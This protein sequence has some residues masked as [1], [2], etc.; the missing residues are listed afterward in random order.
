MLASLMNE[1]RISIEYEAADYA[2]AIREA[3][4]LLEEDGCI[5]PDYTRAC[6]EIVQKMGAYMVLAKGLA[7]PHARPEQGALKTSVSLVILKQPVCFGHAAND[8]VK[9]VFCLAATD[10]SGHLSA[11]QDIAMFALNR[12]RFDRLATMRDPAEAFAYIRELA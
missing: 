1:R 12:P 9:I 10:N 11:L 8:P 5:T 6:I 2:D 4:R 3:G 7:L